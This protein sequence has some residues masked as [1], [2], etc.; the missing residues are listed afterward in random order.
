MTLII[1]GIGGAVLVCAIVALIL[2]SRNHHSHH[3]AP[4]A[5][6]PAAPKPATP[7]LSP[8]AVERLE[9]ATKLAFEQAVAKA[10]AQFDA[11]LDGTSKRLNQLIVSLT[12]DVVQ[13]ELEEYRASLVA[14]REQAL[15]GVHEM[16]SAIEKQQQ[17][18][19]AELDEVVEKRRQFMIDQLDARIGQIAATYI[20]ESL[21]K[22]VDLGA[23]RDYLISSLEAN[24]NDLVR[25]IRGQL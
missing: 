8:E 21:G 5:V 17:S 16:Q 10:S 12:T 14:A 9:N 15:A 7:T 18:I 3:E 11:D 13:K 1:A 25:D 19:K 24:K 22:G 20:M 2:A 23:Q 6:P 4:V